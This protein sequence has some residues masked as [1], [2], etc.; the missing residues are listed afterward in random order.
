MI[1]CMALAVKNLL[2]RPLR[3]A[4]TVGGVALAVAVLYSLASFQKGYQEHLRAELAGLGAHILVVPKGCPYE[5]AS[6]AI[7][8]ANWPR[9]LR[10]ADLPALV[11]APGVRHAAGVLM[12][13]T[14]DPRTAQQQIWL[15]VDGAIRSVKPFWRIAGRFPAAPDEAL[16]GSEV[17]RRRGLRPG[18]PFVDGTLA[19]ALR[20]SGVLARTGGQDDSFVYLPRATAQRLFRH[21]GQITNI[22]VT[23]DDPE[24]VIEVAAAMRRR[25]PDANVIPMAQVLQTMLNLARTTRR[26][27]LCVVLIALLISV[28]GVVNAVMTS[29]FERT[30]EIGM[31]RAVGASRGE[32]FRLVWTET[33]LVCLLGGVIGNGLALLLSRGIEAVVRGQLP[34][35]PRGTLIAPDAGVF[36]AC[37]VGAAL[38]G[39]VAGLLPAARA[40]ALRPVE[41]IRGGY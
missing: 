21:P 13:A 40:C 24:R 17:A 9:Y 7:H 41:A 1:T 36:L 34:Y 3:T 27:V 37:V 26:L 22:L 23:V 10:E 25:D 18:A 4:L 15:G 39:A 33:L 32:V 6:I 8:G 31:L 2:R 20:V 30:G 35:A 5:A 19:A 28:F 29:V 16:V 11:G 12:S 14:T 38:L